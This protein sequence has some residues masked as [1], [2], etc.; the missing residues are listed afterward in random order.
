M[1]EQTNT[2]ATQ[3]QLVKTFAT[4]LNDPQVKLADLQSHLAALDA[5]SRIRECRA[6]NRRQQALLYQVAGEVAVGPDDMVKGAA[7]GEMV[8]WYGKNSLPAFRLFEKRFIRHEGKVVGFNFNPPL[9]T[10]F[11]GPGYYVCRVDEIKPKELLI[12]YTLIP[13]TAPVG[14]PKVEH[15]MAGFSRFVYG[16]MYDYCRKV[17]DTIVIGAATRKGKSIGQYFILC[18][19]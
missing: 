11:T 18:R 9:V 7:D 2:L 6:L 8:R 5:E 17:S 19:G 16:G 13:D 10:W 3:G 15:N 12:D 4:L 14:W 1:A